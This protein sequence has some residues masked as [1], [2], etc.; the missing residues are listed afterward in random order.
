MRYLPVHARR[1]FTLIELLVVMAIIAVLVGLLMSGVQKVRE[2]ASRMSCSNNLHQIGLGMQMHHDTY[3]VFPSNGGWDG[4]QSIVSSSGQPTFVG[5]NI[6]GKPPNIWGVGDPQLAPFTQ[7]GS[8]AYAILP[9]IEQQQMYQQR[10]WTVG[11]KLFMCPSRR[12]PDPQLVPNKDEYSTYNGGGWAWG[13]TD[14]AANALVIP[15][16]PLCLRIANLTD[17]TS[18]T[19]LAGE[20]AMAPKNYATGT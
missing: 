1:A 13:K 11:I 12:S 6:Q 7:T 10:V 14:Y 17:G 19:V 15:K 2:A 3:G 5:T 20:K 8:W 4:R 18:Q 16:R 9:F